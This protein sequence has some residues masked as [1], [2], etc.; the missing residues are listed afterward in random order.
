M[1]R[2]VDKWHR[3]Q[4]RTRKTLHNSWAH[5]IF[6]ARI[7]HHDIWHVDKRNL[8]YGA[9]MG[10]FISFTPTI[11]FQMLL[12]TIGAMLFKINLP[13]AL[14]GCFTTNP[15]TALPVYLFARNLGRFILNNTWLATVTID[16]FEFK[17][18]SGVFMEQSIYLWTGCLIIGA[19]AAIIGYFAVGII[20]NMMHSMKQKITHLRSEDND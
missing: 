17:G 1:I 19:V 18:K 2:L 12:C 20:W 4:E 14:A 5:R 13:I 16:L 3:W 6:G 10:L 8:T 11:P 9:A 15:V 7:F